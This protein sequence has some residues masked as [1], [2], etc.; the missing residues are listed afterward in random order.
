MRLSQAL[1]TGALVA[2]IGLC[3]QGQTPQNPPA[4]DAPV[5]AKGMPPRATPADYQAHTQAGTLTIAAEFAGHTVPSPPQVPLSTEDFVSV[6]VGLFGPPDA[7]VKISTDDFT[8]RIN[9]KKTPLSSQPYGMVIGNVKDPE[10]EPPEKVEAKSKTSLGSGG[11]QSD[12]PEAGALPP[13]VHIPIEVQRAM[14]LRVRKAALPEGDRTL[15]V[16]GLIFFQYRGKVQGIHSMELIYAGP[17]GKATL[18][19]QP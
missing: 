14:A 17:A 3:V 11:G 15:P 1:R 9:G 8:L 7:K 12:K 16:A 6:E 19:L 18:A 5:E 10:W 13:V 4:K 2:A